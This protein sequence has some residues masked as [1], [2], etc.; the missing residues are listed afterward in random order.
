MWFSRRSRGH[1]G[2][3][4]DCGDQESTG[5]KANIGAAAGEITQLLQDV[6]VGSQA[7]RDELFAI[8]YGELKEIARRQLRSVPA[9]QTLQTTALVHEAYVK[10]ARPTDSSFQNRAHFFAVAARAM[11]QISI[12]HVR[13]RTSGKRGGGAAPLSVELDRL[14]QRGDPEAELLTLHD[15]LEELETLDSRLGQVVELRFFGGLTVEEV[16]LVLDVSARTIKRDWRR[17]RAFLQSRLILED[18]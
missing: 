11:R 13:A 10:L 9:G 2:E 12:D 5:R 18:G 4:S 16:G 15:A 1:S 6:R 14:S 8:V 3:S 17:A 7:V